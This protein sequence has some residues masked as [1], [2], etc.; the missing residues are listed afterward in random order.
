MSIHNTHNQSTY[1]YILRLQKGYQIFIRDTKFYYLGI[2]PGYQHIWLK[3]T[4][5]LAT[6]QSPSFPVSIILELI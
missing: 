2:R 5:V 1:F 4:H 6:R 3:S